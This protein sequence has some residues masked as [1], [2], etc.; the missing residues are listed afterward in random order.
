VHIDSTAIAAKV[1][2]AIQW[3]QN[4]SP[5]HFALF[6]LAITDFLIAGSSRGRAGSVSTAPGCIWIGNIFKYDDW[7]VAEILV[8]ELVHT[9]VFL[10]ENQHCH[11]DYSRIS[12]P[13]N[14]AVSSILK[15]PRPVNKV[16]HS[17]IVA[18]ELILFRKFVG[19][20]T[21]IHRVHPPTTDLLG[22]LYTS[23]S[24]LQDLLVRE[25]SIIT[26]RA[27]ALLA[28]CQRSLMSFSPKTKASPHAI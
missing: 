17:I 6:N 20:A 5:Q 16:F 9:L 7:E 22:Q 19:Q 24:G 11:Y 25:P 15:M 27:A 21:K 13:E 18:T 2:L 14:Y 12:K 4:H 26:T 3:L 10:D 23:I 1:N 8:H 28:K